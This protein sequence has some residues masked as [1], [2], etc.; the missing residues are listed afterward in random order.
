MKQCLLLMAAA[1]LAS[2][3]SV[4]RDAGLTEVQQAVSARTQQDVTLKPDDERL[5]A[6]L[7]DELTA[8]EAVAIAMANNPRLQ[9]TLAE[10][11]IARADLIEASTIAN[12]IFEF[13]LRVPG[14]PYRPY[15]LRLAQI[16]HRPDPAPAPPRCRPRRVRR[17]AD[18]R[19]L[20]GAAV[21]ARTCA[22][23]TT[24]SLAAIAARGAERARS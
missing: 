11:G 18:A 1:L 13:E 17:R 14:E 23:R 7:Q 9:V 15:E 21:R 5:R 4:P 24:T 8:D 20:G 22:R 2:C 3:A 6:M 12:P 19:D 16:A 10:L